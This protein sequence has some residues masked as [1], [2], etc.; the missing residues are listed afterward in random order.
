MIVVAAAVVLALAG[1]GGGKESGTTSTTTPARDPGREVMGT[2]VTAAAA[3]DS[4]TMWELL[5]RPSR[6]RAGPTLATFAAGPA[7]ELRRTLAP[8]ARGTLPVQVSEN[9]SDRFG[10]VALSRGPHAYAVPLRREGDLW[11]VELP[12][13]LRIEVL[14][15]PPGSKGKFVNQIGVELHGEG[16]EGPAV[17][18]ADGVTLDAR[19]Y[20][21][22]KSA[23]V[24]ANLATSL[25]KGRHT[26]VAYAERGDN[27]AARAWTF[28]SS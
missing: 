6:R 23:T 20:G 28:V 5:S 7:K 17:I 26:A 16:P 4:A 21:G 8:F 1:C 11:R 14:G 3:G 9:I 19:E 25:E 22:R 13:P 18:Y 2:F 15:P 27:A 12:G 10:V 24:F